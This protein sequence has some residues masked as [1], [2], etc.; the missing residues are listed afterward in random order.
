M[1]IVV[2]LLPLS[3]VA[4]NYLIADLRD[5]RRPNPDTICG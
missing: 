5:R 2:T 4:A 1:N 3:L